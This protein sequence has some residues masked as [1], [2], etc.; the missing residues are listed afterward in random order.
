MEMIV[1][2]DVIHN[3]SREFPRLDEKTPYDSLWCGTE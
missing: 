1:E 3:K 2:D